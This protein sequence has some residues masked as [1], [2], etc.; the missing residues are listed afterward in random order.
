MLEQLKAAGK[1]VAA[2]KKVL[3][4]FSGAVLGGFVSG[5]VVKCASRPEPVPVTIQM[6]AYEIEL[7]KIDAKLDSISKR[8]LHSVDESIRIL[9][10]RYR[11][12]ASK[13][14]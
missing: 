9:T 2:L 3:P 4:Y 12:E 5:T 7:K 6:P 13:R 8:P 10:E 11:E 1:V 14:K